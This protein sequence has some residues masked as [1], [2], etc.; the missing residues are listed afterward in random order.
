MPFPEDRSESLRAEAD[1]VELLLAECLELPVAERAA[2]VERA[3]G[4]H[5]E[6]ARGMRRRIEALSALGIEVL[7][8]EVEAADFPEQLGDF[9]LMGRI[10]GGGMGVVYLAV[11]TSL[12]RD[13]ALKLIRPEHLFFEG[14]RERFRR[15]AQAVA[16]LQHPGIVPIY[17]VGED[18]GIPWF[19]MEHVAGCTLAQV[20]VEL[21][22]RAPESLS[23]A[24]LHR[25]VAS[26]AGSAEPAPE[27]SLF[28]RTWVEACLRL[29]LGVAEALEHAHG[30]GILHRDVKPS[31]V[32][33]TPDGR[34]L[35]LDFGLT[36]AGRGDHVTRTGSQLGTL[37]Y[38]SPEQVR[39]RDVDART[40]VYSLGAALYELLTLQV[41]YRGDDDLET[42]R[43]I[44]DGSPDSIRAR[45][46]GVEPDVEIVCLKAMDRDPERRYAGTA[47]FA[48]DLQNL[49]AHRP[50][51]ARP[52]G[53]VLRTRRWVQRHPARAT[54]ALL[55]LLL[56]V[57]TPT[58]LLIQERAHAGRLRASLENERQARERA[59]LSAAMA[60]REGRTTA[61]TLQFLTGLFYE[62]SSTVAAGE[63]LTA[64]GVLQYGANRVEQEFDDPYQQGRTLLALGRVHRDLHEYQLALPVLERALSAFAE[65]DPEG[66]AEPGLVSSRRAFI[67]GAHLSLAECLRAVGRTAE[68]ERHAE[69]A[70]ELW[71]DLRGAD[72]PYVEH[73]EIVLAGIWSD[74]GHDEQAEDLRREVLER[75]RARGDLP[76]EEVAR[77]MAHLAASLLKQRRFEEGEELLSPALETLLQVLPPRHPDRVSMLGNAGFAAKGLGRLDQAQ[78]YY[79]EALGL[80]R[81]IWPGDNATV[82]GLLLNR[83]GLLEARGELEESVA[84]HR[85]AAGLFRQLLPED[86]PSLAVAL[87]NLAGILS[88][89]ELCEEA[90][91]LYAEVLP[92]QQRA[93]GPAHPRVAVSLRNLAR[94]DLARDDAQAAVD[95]LRRARDIL[96]RADG[97]G[98]LRAEVAAELERL[99]G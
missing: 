8:P 81:E 79:D 51:A 67:G 72:V 6:L 74:L 94:C 16:R 29:A 59:Q 91:P 92:L 33:V 14:A 40:D 12:K 64:A 48:R 70:L 62:A 5:P 68:A 73:A 39:G 93:F 71:E 22:G 99:G 30:R 18:G 46:R 4:D 66:D 56:V 52:P 43:L 78:G 31:N 77:A 3:F 28:E 69:R 24:D 23:G 45:N 1:P 95:H 82:A 61:A 9:R 7:P 54:G 13:V 84:A 15:E 44:G 97:W 86:H 25:I 58:A 11:Q 65:E 85:E 47:A 55:G 27:G 96:E 80:A 42:Q 50:V 41:P 60:T 37:H 57:G 89:A 26:A 49:L 10:G 36:S 76:T 98:E 53:P 83:A 87:G 38:M 21:R 34:A 88:K 75:M 2:A 90:G 19:A 17:T 20:L 32:M 35:L 63:T